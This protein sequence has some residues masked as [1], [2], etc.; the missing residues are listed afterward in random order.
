MMKLFLLTLLSAPVFSSMQRYED[1]PAEPEVEEIYAEE[2]EEPD[3]DE[4]TSQ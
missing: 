3:D 1:D 4:E 2:S